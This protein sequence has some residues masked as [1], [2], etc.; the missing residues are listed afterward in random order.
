MRTI[1]LTLG[2]F[3]VVDDDDYKWLTQ[4]LWHAAKG[5]RRWYAQR[6]EGADT[7]YMHRLILGLKKDGGLVSHH[8]GHS[9]DNRRMKLLVC[10]NN[11]HRRVHQQ[12]KQR[13]FSRT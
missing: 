3:T 11:E 1:Q 8:K 2:K 12:G 9:L 5:G 6:S 4:W 10:D 13:F 7:I